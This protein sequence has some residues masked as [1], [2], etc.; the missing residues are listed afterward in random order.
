MGSTA[1]GSRG[2]SANWLSVRRSRDLVFSI[3]WTDSGVGVTGELI[4]AGTAPKFDLSDRLKGNIAVIDCPTS[5]RPYSEWYK[6]WGV[7]PAHLKFPSSVRPRD[8]R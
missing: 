8:L 2:D 7:Y 4:Y 1:L 3:F 5:E 6:I